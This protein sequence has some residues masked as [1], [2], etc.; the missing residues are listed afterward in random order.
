MI[1]YVPLGMEWHAPTLERVKASKSRGVLQASPSV[2]M[3]A[4]FSDEPNKP[5]IKIAPPT[6]YVFMF[7]IR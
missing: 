4:A 6:R 5:T 3:F 7:N 1:M 2:F